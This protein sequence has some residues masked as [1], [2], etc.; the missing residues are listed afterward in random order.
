MAGEGEDESIDRAVG[1]G[2]MVGCRVNDF[3]V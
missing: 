1:D 2:Q 3:D